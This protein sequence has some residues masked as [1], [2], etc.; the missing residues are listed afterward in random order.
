MH[1]IRYEVFPAAT[2]QKKMFDICNRIAVRNGDTGHGIDSIR[3]ID[4]TF[5]DES[6]ATEY[7][8]RNDKHFYDCLAVKFLEYDAPAKS[9]KLDDIDTRILAERE[10][11]AEY[12]QAHSVKALKAEFVGCPTCGSRLKRE[13]IHGN[14][15]PLCRTDLR[16]KTTLTTIERKRVTISNLQEKRAEEERKVNAKREGR[17]MWLVKFEYHC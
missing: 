11:L 5:A 6:A 14:A 1:E 7:I 2:T 12:E 8:R 10:K 16:S 15:C 3:F 13:L 4:K 17:E 9:K